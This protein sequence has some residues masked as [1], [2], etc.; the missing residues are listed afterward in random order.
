MTNVQ[1]SHWALWARVF[2]KVF[3]YYIFQMVSRKR[4][5]YESMSSR[6]RIMGTRTRGIK[7]EWWGFVYPCVPV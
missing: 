4:H 2:L 6:S 3:I 5:V 7:M 1:R